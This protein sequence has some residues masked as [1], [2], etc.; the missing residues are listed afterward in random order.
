M[1]VCHSNILIA[2][3]VLCSYLAIC[4]EMNLSDIEREGR[5]QKLLKVNGGPFHNAAGIELDTIP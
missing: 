3:T 4:L 5:L 1:L 2:F